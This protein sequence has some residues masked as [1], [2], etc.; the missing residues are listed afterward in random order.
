METYEKLLKSSDSFSHV[1]EKLLS[2]AP[3]EHKKIISCIIDVYDSRLIRAYCK[4]RFTIININILDILSLCLHGKNRILEVG[5]GFG[6]FGCYFAALNPDV[7]YLGYDLNPRRVEMANLAATRLGLQNASFHCANARELSVNEQF[8]AVMLVDLMHHVDDETK[9]RL[10][11]MAAGQLTPGGRLI[12]KD[13]TTHPSFK[14]GFTWALD[15]LM[16]RSFDMHY[17][18]ENQFHAALQR[19]FKAIKTYPIVDWLP[20]PHI[21]YFCESPLSARDSAP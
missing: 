2:A 8:D 7:Q 5:C 11:T 13:V 17:W 10:V 3:H 9:K 12:I 19:H 14:I 15:V 4:S 20:Y 1:G 18:N 21:V 6:L 16:T